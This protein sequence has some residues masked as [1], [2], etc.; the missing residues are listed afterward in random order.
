MELFPEGEGGSV[1]GDKAIFN[2]SK[3]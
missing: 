1:V 3:F 2:Q